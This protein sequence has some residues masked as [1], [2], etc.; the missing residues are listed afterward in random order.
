MAGAFFLEVNMKNRIPGPIMKRIIGL[1]L[2]TTGVAVIGTIL[3]VVG[4]DKTT[5]LLSVALTSAFLI[6]M[7]S[8][9]RIST[10]GEYD[11]YEGILLAR[12]PLPFRKK[13]EITLLRGDA[14]EQIMLQGKTPL[15]VGDTYRIY[16]E[17]IHPSFQDTALAPQFLPG[18]SLLG[19]EHITEATAPEK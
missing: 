6:K 14:Q 13:Q 4:N 9:Y 1:G 5:A 7:I 15:R 3:G 17:K 16:L 12:T 18:R 19:Y 2:C 10:T 11:I 8:L